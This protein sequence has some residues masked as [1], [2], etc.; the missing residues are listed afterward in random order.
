MRL[1]RHYNKTS[2]IEQ[3][4][5]NNSKI[6]A[7]NLFIKSIIGVYTPVNSSNMEAEHS[8]NTLSHGAPLLPNCSA[9]KYS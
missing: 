4:K 9:F 6:Y 5:K 3:K 7:I 2:F 8:L 1:I